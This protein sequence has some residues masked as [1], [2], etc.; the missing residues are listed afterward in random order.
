MRPTDLEMTATVSLISS[1]Q[2]EGH[3][4]S[5][6]KHQG[7]SGCRDEWA[8]SGMEVALWLLRG[9]TGWLRVSRLGVG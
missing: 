9:R 3:T 7:G 5:P 6:G 8:K 4:R 1:S 2:E